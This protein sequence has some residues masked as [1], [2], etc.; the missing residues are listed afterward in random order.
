MPYSYSP[1]HITLMA[2]VDDYC[3]VLVTL[4]PRTAFISQ[5]KHLPLPGKTHLDLIW[6]EICLPREK[7]VVSI[8]REP[9]VV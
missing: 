4:Q 5:T 9:T 3:R 8:A 6:G 7:E 2:V 1:L